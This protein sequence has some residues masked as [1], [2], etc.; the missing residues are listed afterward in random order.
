MKI[1]TL[2]EHSIFW[3]EMGQLEKPVCGKS[4]NVHIFPNCILLCSGSK[5]NTISS[6]E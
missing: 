5:K 4:N 2:G 1:E 3:Q 6:E